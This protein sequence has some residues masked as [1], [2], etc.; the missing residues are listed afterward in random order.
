MR[1][2]DYAASRP[3]A[4]PARIG[5]LGLSMGGM[6]ALLLAALDPRI[7]VVV[8]VAGQLSWQDIFAGESWKRI[9]AGMEMTGPLA[10]AGVSGREARRVFMERFP[11][12]AIIDIWRALRDRC[13]WP[14]AAVDSLSLMNTRFSGRT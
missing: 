10:R 2:V 3:E 13:N 11:P 12:M 7:G 9:F 8:S 5:M 4:D 14:V 1:A 6:E